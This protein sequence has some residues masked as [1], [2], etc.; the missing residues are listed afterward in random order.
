[1]YIKSIT[2]LWNRFISFTKTPTFFN[3]LILSICGL[4]VITYYTFLSTLQKSLKDVKPALTP[5]QQY[6]ED[7]KK[8]FLQLWEDS[9]A[10]RNVDDFFYDHEQYQKALLNVTETEKKWKSRILYDTTPSGNVIM[11]YDIYKHGFAYASDHTIP[12]HI[13]CGCAMKY[14]KLFMCRDFFRD[15][16]YTKDEELSP[17]TKMDLEEEKREKRK[18][19]AKRN[20]LNLDFNSDAFLKPKPKENPNKVQKKV[21][22]VENAVEKPKDYYKNIFRY[23]G[24][25]SEVPLLQTSNY[26]IETPFEK[27]NSYSYASFKKKTKHTYFNDFFSDSLDMNVIRYG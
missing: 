26:K 12:Y 17:F 27:V 25:M 1:M 11:Y 24:K 20:K 5:V 9:Y 16:L 7:R 19:K 23:L 18:Q 13:L 21:Y 3:I 14:C 15:N 8:M 6:L 4:S 2:L 22:I 10:N